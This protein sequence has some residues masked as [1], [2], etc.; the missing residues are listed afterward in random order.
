MGTSQPGVAPHPPPRVH[1]EDGEDRWA[2]PGGGAHPAT[3]LSRSPVAPPALITEHTCPPSLP[4]LCSACSRENARPR[5]ESDE[6]DSGMDEP[7]AA[8]T[9][10]QVGAWC[11]RCAEGTCGRGGIAT[12]HG[13]EG[14]AGRNSSTWAL[15]A[16]CRPCPHRRPGRY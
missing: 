16:P 15:P 14:A 6:A 1:G 5:Q 12:G 4:L 2:P 10:Q 9:Y 3:L 11:K 8:S 13:R 7:L